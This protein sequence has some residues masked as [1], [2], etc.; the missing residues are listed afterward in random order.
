MHHLNAVIW[1][2]GRWDRTKHFNF[3][4]ISYRLKNHRE[5]ESRTRNASEVDGG[6]VLG[7]FALTVHIIYYTSPKL[8]YSTNPNYQR[9]NSDSWKNS[10]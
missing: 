6:D 1:T 8:Y 10:L 9:H 2:K 3:F 7:G 5:D 4:L